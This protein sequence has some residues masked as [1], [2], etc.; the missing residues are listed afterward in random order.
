MRKLIGNHQLRRLRIGW[1]ENIMMD[2]RERFCVEG[3]DW[4]LNQNDD[5]TVF[6]YHTLQVIQF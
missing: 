4:G 5:E 6:W 3:A 2:F 1:E